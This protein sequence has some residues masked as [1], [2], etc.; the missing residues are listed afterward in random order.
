MRTVKNGVITMDILCTDHLCK[1]YGSG[2]TQV[3]AVDD[4]SFT[5][6][7]GENVTVVSASGG[8]RLEPHLPPGHFAG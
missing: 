2:S 7:K 3:T 5:L 8:A 1:T 4:A 6:Q